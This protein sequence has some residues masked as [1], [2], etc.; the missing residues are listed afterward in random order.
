MISQVAPK[1]IANFMNQM[2]VE[3]QYA[4]LMEYPPLTIDS[5]T[6]VFGDGYTRG[7]VYWH[8]VGGLMT[9]VTEVRF[10]G[11]PKFSVIR[12]VG[13]HASPE[14]DELAGWGVLRDPVKVTGHNVE[15]ARGS[16]S[17]RVS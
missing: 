11:I 6:E 14:S 12:A 4:S 7:R 5:F 8:A 9:N 1:F 10:T 17:I 3:M 2:Q 15:L 16:I 13:L